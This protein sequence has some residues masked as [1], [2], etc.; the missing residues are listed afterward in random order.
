MRLL[1]GFKDFRRRQ[2]L[3]E[4]GAALPH[5]QEFEHQLAVLLDGQHGDSE[6]RQGGGVRLPHKFNPG[7]ARK[8]DIQQRD[9]RKIPRDNTRRTKAALRLLLAG[10]IGALR[11]P[12]KV[13]AGSVLAEYCRCTGRI[14]LE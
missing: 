2:I 6:R 1:N 8:V 7:L 14:L 13:P 12:A 9:V 10:G 3:H 4:V 5:L 11:L